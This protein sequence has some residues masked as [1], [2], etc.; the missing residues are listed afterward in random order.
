MS[1]ERVGPLLLTSFIGRRGHL[2]VWRNEGASRAFSQAWCA[3]GPHRVLAASPRALSHSLLLVFTV[4]G[5]RRCC[6]RWPNGSSEHLPGAL[7]NIKGSSKVSEGRGVRKG[8]WAR[9][10]GGG[11]SR[12]F[13]APREE[14]EGMD[15]GMDRNAC[16]REG[17]NMV[18]LSSG[19]EYSAH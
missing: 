13:T 8:W 10:G 18:V 3:G 9:V 15:R 12:V 7:S 6:A 5:Y 2:R 1:P 4:L 16:G 14:R 19:G 17:K 11:L